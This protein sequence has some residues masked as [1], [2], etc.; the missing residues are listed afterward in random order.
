M[1]LAFGDAARHWDAASRKYNRW[2]LAASGE[3]TLRKRDL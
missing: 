3:V 2:K 1:P